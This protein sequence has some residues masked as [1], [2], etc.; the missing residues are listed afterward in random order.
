MQAE[1]AILKKMESN[2]DK[3]ASPAQYNKQNPSTEQEKNHDGG[4]T[5]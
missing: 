3:L 4:G 2:I 5:A 1:E